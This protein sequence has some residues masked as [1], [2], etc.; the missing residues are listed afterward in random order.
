MAGRAPGRRWTEGVHGGYRPMVR[1]HTR[2]PLE[3]NGSKRGQGEASLEER[4]GERE[5]EGEKTSRGRTQ[6][7]H[8]PPRRRMAWGLPCAEAPDESTITIDHTSSPIIP[9]RRPIKA[10]RRDTPHVP[11][12]SGGRDDDIEGVLGPQAPEAPRKRCLGE[13]RAVIT[14]NGTQETTAR[15]ASCPSHR[16]PLRPMTRTIAATQGPAMSAART[17]TRPTPTNRRMCREPVHTAARPKAAARPERQR[18]R[19]RSLPLCILPSRERILHSARLGDAPAD[20]KCAE[21]RQSTVEHVFNP[22]R[23]ACGSAVAMRLT[24]GPRVLRGGTLDESA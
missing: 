4:K 5:S 19:K 11:Q 15:E 1:G 7:A 24:L 17:S 21:L 13:D 9:R 10:S 6:R 14:C 12:A 22:S 20:G 16:D 8:A 18:A 3:R 23:A 2:M